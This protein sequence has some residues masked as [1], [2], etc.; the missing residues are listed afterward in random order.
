MLTSYLKNLLIAYSIQLH[1]ALPQPSLGNSGQGFHS[2]CIHN[3]VV[4]ARN[5]HNLKESTERVLYSVS[6]RFLKKPSLSTLS[7]HLL[8][9][10]QAGF[11]A[12]SSCS[13]QHPTGHPQ[14]DNGFQGCTGGSIMLLATFSYFF[15][16][17]HLWSLLEKRPWADTVHSSLRYQKECVP[18]PRCSA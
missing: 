8:Q 5:K 2:G 11:L 17:I 6:P 1:L 15:L 13:T 12:T 16:D 4:K 18:S 14:P 10:Q 3:P 7:L 9:E